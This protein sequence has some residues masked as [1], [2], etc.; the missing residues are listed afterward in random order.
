MNAAEW[1][2]SQIGLGTPV[3]VIGGP[4]DVPPPAPAPPPPPSEVAVPPATTAPTD[5]VGQ[6]VDGLLG[7]GDQE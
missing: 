2:P 4:E 6:L 1:L 3:F 5:R 7:G